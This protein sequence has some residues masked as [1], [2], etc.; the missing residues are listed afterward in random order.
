MGS[1]IRNKYAPVLNYSLRRRFFKDGKALPWQ[2]HGK[3][4]YF[5]IKIVQKQI[6]L[7]IACGRIVEIEFIHNKIQLDYYGYPTKKR[8]IFN[9]GT[10]AP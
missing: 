7:L 10:N 9:M 8:L 3:G 4:T 1:G 6:D 5:N 2:D